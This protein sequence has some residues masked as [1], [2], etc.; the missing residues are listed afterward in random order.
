LAGAAADAGFMDSHSDRLRAIIAT[1]TEIAGS[2]L[3]LLAAMSLIAERSQELTRASGAVVEIVDGEEM[4]YEVTT[5]DATPYLGMRLALADSLSGLCV[6]EGRL[7]RSDDTSVDPRVDGDACQ[8]VGA[9][10]MICVPLSHRREPVGVLKV[11]SNLVANFTDD[12]VETLELLTDLIAAQ[13]SHATRF[14]VE[15]YEN[16]HDSLTGLY[17]RRAY[18][19]RLAVETSRA[20]RYEQP[21]S[22]CLLDLDGFKDL[23]DRHGHAAGDEVLCDVARLIDDSRVADDAFRIGGDEFAVLMPQTAPTEARIAAERLARRIVDAKLGGGSIG[24]SFGI[25]AG[26][27]DPELSHLAADTALLRAKDRLYG[28]SD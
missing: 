22:I 12:D 23:N 1:Q 5:G 10:S 8:R 3:D 13:I 25:A 19:E 11:Y 16:R 14:E 28:Q 15:A 27:S 2:D 7:L 24:V 17:N 18:E 4:V 26:S 9:A 6:E 20:T 21:L